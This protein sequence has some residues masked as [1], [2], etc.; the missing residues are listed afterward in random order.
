M[1]NLIDAAKCLNRE[2]YS[3]D[4]YDEALLQIAICGED[5]IIAYANK[6]FEKP[7]IDLP[8]PLKIVLVRLAA[9]ISNS[10]ANEQKTLNYLATLSALCDSPDEKFIVDPIRK[11][12]EEKREN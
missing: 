5:E 1:I 6:I 7:L 4:S 11:R 2:N 9:L 12:I 8:M 3:A 10:Q